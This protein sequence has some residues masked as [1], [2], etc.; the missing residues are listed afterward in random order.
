MDAVSIG[1][2][3]VVFAVSVV[4]GAVFVLFTGGV[5]SVLAVSA[6]GW[7]VALAISS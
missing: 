3:G 7:P 6:S 4:S 1:V 5:V 2:V